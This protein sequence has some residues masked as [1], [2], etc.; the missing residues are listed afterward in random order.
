MDWKSL[1]ISMNRNRIIKVKSQIEIRIKVKWLQKGIRICKKVMRI[2]N[3]GC[4]SLTNARRQVISL[5]N[6]RQQTKQ[7]DSLNRSG[8]QEVRQIP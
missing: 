4:A 1:K 5:K 8:Q 6:T 2:R 3:P 7:S